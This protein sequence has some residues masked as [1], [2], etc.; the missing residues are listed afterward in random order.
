M[1][2]KL[3]TS[4]SSCSPSPFWLVLLMINGAEEVLSSFKIVAVKTLGETRD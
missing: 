2:S 1:K 3:A 4:G